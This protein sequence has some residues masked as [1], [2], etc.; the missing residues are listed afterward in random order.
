[1][2]L[3]H[4]APTTSF[5]LTLHMHALLNMNPIY[6]LYFRKCSNTYGVPTISV[7]MPA[8]LSQPPMLFIKW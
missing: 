2:S 5:C 6:V 8:L 7:L 4:V 3:K 1:V